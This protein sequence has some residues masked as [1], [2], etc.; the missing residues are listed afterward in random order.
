MDDKLFW[1]ILLTVVLRLHHVLA[2]VAEHCIAVIG[3]AD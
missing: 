1:V 2:V 3:R